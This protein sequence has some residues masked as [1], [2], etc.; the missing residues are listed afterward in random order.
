MEKYLDVLAKTALFNNIKADDLKT[1]LACL[2][3]KISKF[4]KDDLLAAAGEKFENMGI[5]LSGEAVVSKENA[6]GNRTIMAILKP[7]DLFGEVVVFS[8][9]SVWPATI[10]A[11][12]PCLAMFLSRRKILGQ[13]ENICSWHSTIIENMLKLISDK[14]LMLNKQVE[15]LSMKSM[16]GKISS[17]LIEQ[18]EK[19]L[20]TRFILPMTRHELAD[21]L[22]VSRP[23]MS[24]EMGRMR[25]E[26]VLDFHKSSFYIK[27]LAALR[28]MAE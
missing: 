7:G 3:P 17:F 14:T 11:Q 16:R 4:N 13:C 15:Y 27:D 26:G 23:S 20:N 22:N 28:Q 9:K 21:F 5:M 25:D 6:A 10:V 12:K 1:M 19:A 24:R 8:H 18:S 2:K